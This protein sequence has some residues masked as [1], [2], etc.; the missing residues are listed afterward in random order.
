MKKYNQSEAIEKRERL[1]DQRRQQFNAIVDRIVK[2]ALADQK[3]TYM[4]VLAICIVV[5]FLLGALTRFIP[6]G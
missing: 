1:Q 5:A 6:F 3:K 4:Y 2:K